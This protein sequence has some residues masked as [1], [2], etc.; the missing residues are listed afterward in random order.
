MSEAI[1]YLPIMP[2]PKPDSIIQIIGKLLFPKQ[3]PWEQRKSLITMFWT[4]FIA[5]C[6]G[7]IIAAFA[8]FQNSRH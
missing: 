7:V 5:L 1:K 8:L 3:S 2:F 6:F 4:T